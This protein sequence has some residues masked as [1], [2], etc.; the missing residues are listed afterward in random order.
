MYNFGKFINACGYRYYKC[1]TTEAD[2]NT[3]SDS[4]VKGKKR[5]FVLPA[6]LNCEYDD[7]AC[8]NEYQAKDMPLDLTIYE[9][10]IKE[11]DAKKAA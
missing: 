3:S 6:P 5:T 11:V 8:R 7:R 4:K 1:R 9:S 2:G 10:L